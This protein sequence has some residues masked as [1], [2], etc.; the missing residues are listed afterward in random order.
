MVPQN[1]RIK[2]QKIGQL[3]YI[4]HLDLCR[5][6]TPAMIR[7]GIPIWYTEGFNPHPKM[8]FTQPLPLFA[9]SVCEYL[10]I[11]IVENMSCEEIK[12]RL[13]GALASELAVSEV[14][15]PS[16]KFTE[17][18]YAEYVISGLGGITPEM[19]EIALAGA[20]EIGKRTKSGQVKT[21]DIRPQVRSAEIIDGVIKCVL[22]A[23]GASY[24]NPD[25][26]CKGLI[27]KLSLDSET[28]FSIMRVGWLKADGTEFE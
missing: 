22:D 15:T 9:E 7:A 6:M 2:F 5:T 25:A 23:S 3:K 8:V 19:L 18:A 24:L 28:D 26:F 10:D 16:E 14:Y 11:K 27:G 4:S 13:N 12:E 20:I 1:I 21:V 17:I